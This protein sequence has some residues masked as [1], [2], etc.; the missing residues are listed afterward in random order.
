MTAFGTGG[1][2]TPA[3]P[4]PELHADMKAAVIQTAASAGADL[5]RTKN[6]LGV[7]P[8]RVSIRRSSDSVFT[9]SHNFT[10][11]HRLPDGLFNSLTILGLGGALQS[12]QM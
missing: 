5:G 4:E 10:Q 11:G 6:L 8:F 12:R 3:S 9:A 1:P 7:K 2:V